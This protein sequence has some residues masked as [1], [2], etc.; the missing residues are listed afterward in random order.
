VGPGTAGLGT[1]SQG[2]AEPATADQGTASQGTAEP[3]TPDQGTASQGTAQGTGNTTSGNGTT[4]NGRTGDGPSGLGMAGPAG[5]EISPAAPGPRPG[6]GPGS[7]SRPAADRARIVRHADPL[8]WRPATSPEATGDEDERYVP[9]PAPP[10]RLDPVAKGAWAA[11][12]GGPGYLLLATIMGWQVSG[13][14]ALL[15]IVAFVGGFAVVF[16]RLGDGPPRGD[17]PDNGAVV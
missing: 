3:A 17:G 15:A 5:S 4:G 7:A 12:F 8:A 16:L 13:W 11:L 2:T 9:P 14:S 10:L 6:A 1:A